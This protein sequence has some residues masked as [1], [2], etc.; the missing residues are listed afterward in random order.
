MS[1][2]RRSGRLSVKPPRR[3]ADYAGVIRL[4]AFSKDRPAQLDL[5]L[6]S[7]ERFVP[8]G[9]QTAVVFTASDQLHDR[10]YAVVRDEHPW[11]QWVDER[12]AGGFKAAT[13]G[14]VAG[15]GERLGFLVDDIVFTHP[16]DVDAAPLAALDVDP[17]VLCCSLRLDPGKTY[18]YALDRPM[19]PPPATTWD[20][21]GMEGDWGYPMSLDGHIF[22]T[23]QIAPLLER[24]EYRNPNELEAALADAPLTLPKATCF[25]VARIVNVPDN[26]VQDTAPNR[27]GGGSAAWFT[28]ALL[29][30]RRLDL[31]PFAGLAARS[32]HHEMPLR[33]AAD[34]VAPRVSVV[35]PCHDMAGTLAETLASVAAQE[36][37]GNVEVIVV[38]DGST[39]GSGAL[40]ASLGASVLR[41]P[42]SGHPAHAR[43][44]GFAAARAPYVLPLDADDL[45]EPGFLAATVAA[46]D[47]DPA[48][49]FAYGDVR[50]FGAGEPDELHVTP[51]YGFV[52]LTHRNRHGSASLVRHEAWQAVGGYDAGVGYEDWDLWLGLGQAGWHGVRAEGA[53]FAHRRSAAGRWALDKG[54]DREIKARFVLKR[55]AL[56]DVSQQRW[57]A[58]VLAADP[59]MDS[60]GTEEGVIPSFVAPAAI[61]SRRFAVAALADEILSDPELLRAYGGVFGADDDVSLVIYGSGGVEGL[62]P[63]VA[64]AGLDGPGSPDLLGVE[65]G[66]VQA[67]AVAA[68]SGALLTRRAPQPPFSALPRFDGATLTDLRR[69]ALGEP[70]LQPTPAPA[71]APAPAPAQVHAHA[72]QGGYLAEAPEA[73]AK[74]AHLLSLFHARGHRTL[75]E[76]GTFVGDTVEYFMPHAARIISVEV[77]PKLF[78]DAQRKFLGVPNVELVFGDALHLVPE[79][80]DQLEDPPLIWLDGHFSEG[81][82]GS[83]DEIEPAASI[84]A[85]LGAVRTPAGTTIVVDD[86]RLFGE[87]PDFPGLDELVQRARQGF[88]EARIRV[89]LDSLVIES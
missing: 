76:S 47:A 64:A 10:G 54:R 12:E 39:D 81:V 22:R 48:A 21:A 17:E 25:D 36:L 82:T 3:A 44:T 58:A 45:L 83:G 67:A 9:V 62:G 70:E 59:M 60:L 41:Q 89:G 85:R 35:V 77:E 46:L 7:I 71:V 73:T 13:L 27:H 4:V 38:D 6:R 50:E 53:T 40:A 5:L 28:P 84:L 72:L 65:G 16:L 24:L 32:V 52:E 23:A 75:L 78:A 74:R 1:S 55:P 61:D 34:G 26:R 86:L 79:I 87:H 80:V 57:A 69:L 51:G 56:Y 88:P 33:F 2:A 37:D 49:G 15:A 30:G 8:T 66:I 19:T 63:V 29:A 20:W 11:A 42:A 68:C 18:C 14:L 43:N 31:E